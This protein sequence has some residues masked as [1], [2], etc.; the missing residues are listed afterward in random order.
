MSIE[1]FI[2]EIENRKKKELERLDSEL[3]A[4]KAQ[5]HREKETSVKDLQGRYTKEAK[6]KSERESARIIEAAKL[7]AKRILFD[8]INANLESALTTIREQL[9]NY[10]KGPEYRKVLEFIVDISK[11]KLG[12]N[13]VIHCREEDRSILKELG[14]T[15]GS[16]I[17]TIGGLIAE[18]TEGTKELDM[19]FEELLRN[20]EGQ[21]KAL[22]LEKIS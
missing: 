1:T 20:N 21:I 12:E 18:N 3:A 11:K 13:I 9:K 7:Q 6:A 5:I 14:V 22:F 16:P 15:I 4:K 8:A 17:Q 19:T 10:T 2:Y